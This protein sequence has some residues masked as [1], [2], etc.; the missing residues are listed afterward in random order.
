LIQALYDDDILE[1]EVLCK[2]Y[3]APSKGTIAQVKDAG[4]V[5]VEWLRNAEEESEEDEEA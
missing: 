4:K 2:W 3:D 1:E 5:F